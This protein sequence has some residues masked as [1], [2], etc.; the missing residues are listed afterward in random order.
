MNNLTANLRNE[1]LRRGLALPAEDDVF[2]LLLAEACSQCC[3]DHSGGNGTCP[4]PK[5]QLAE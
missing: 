2:Q 5:W 1:A 3:Q 4:P